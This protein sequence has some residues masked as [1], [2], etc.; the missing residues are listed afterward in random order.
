MT[1]KRALRKLGN[2]QFAE[3]IKTYIKSSHNFF[4]TRV[5]EIKTMAKKLHEEYS[6]KQFYK[7]FNKLWTSGYEKERSLAVYALQMYEEDFDSSTWEFI[8]PKLKEIRDYDQIR[9]IKDILK[10]IIKKCP[11]LKKEISKFV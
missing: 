11:K 2:K 6:L 1:P 8:K 10:G 4:S 9:S 7:V 5:P 3:D